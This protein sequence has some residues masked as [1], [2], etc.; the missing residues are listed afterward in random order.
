M[1]KETFNPKT[2]LEKI[3]FSNVT[4]ISEIPQKKGKEY[5]Y[6]V[7]CNNC[8][9]EFLKAKWTFGVYRCQCYKTIN[10]AYNYQGY[11]AISAV[12]FKSC[13]SNALK[14]N[15]EFNITK[16]DIWKQWLIQNEKCALSGLH[17]TIERNYKKMKEGMT[18]SLDRIDSKKGYTIDNI[19]WIHKH[20][21]KMKMNYDNQYF[22]DMCKLIANNNK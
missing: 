16:E 14:R 19:Q 9:K 11:K 22:I 5:Y 17:L 13:K 3:K 21:N 4:I 8:N 20:L 15:L 10:G 7:K 6:L 1:R 12:Y 2:S 18:A